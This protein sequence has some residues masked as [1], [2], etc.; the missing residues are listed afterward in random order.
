IRAL[1]D[2][3]HIDVLG[4]TV[5]ESPSGH[6]AFD[7]LMAIPEHRRRKMFEGDWGAHQGEKD[8]Q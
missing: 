8:T 3:L 2:Q 6:S 4:P 1:G 5:P 7:E